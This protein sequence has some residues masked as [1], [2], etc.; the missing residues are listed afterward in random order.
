[1]KNQEKV[2]LV[3]VYH[4]YEEAALSCGFSPSM[5]GFH[6]LVAAAQMWAE[7]YNIHRFAPKVT[8]EIYPVIAAEYHVSR[9]TVEHSIRTCIA[10]CFDMPI[11]FDHFLVATGFWADTNHLSNN[12]VIALL[13]RYTMRREEEKKLFV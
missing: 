10:R 6:F 9:Q 12:T 5:D 1:M 2:K 4:I 3:P 13:A 11:R 7:Y 8:K